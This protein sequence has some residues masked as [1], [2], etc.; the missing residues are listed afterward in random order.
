MHE[1]VGNL[2]TFKSLA[3]VTVPYMVIVICLL[4]SV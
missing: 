2:E 1:N 4:T 3:L